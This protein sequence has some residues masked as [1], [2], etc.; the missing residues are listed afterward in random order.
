MNTWISAS[1]GRLAV[2]ALLAAS[3]GLCGS[4]L[5]AHELSAPILALT[6]NGVLEGVRAGGVDEFLGVPYAAPPIGALRFRPPAPHAPW[7]APLRATAFGSPCPQDAALGTP[8]TNE[9]CLSLNIFRPD[10]GGPRRPFLVFFFGGSFKNGSAGVGKSPVGPNYDGA[11]IAQRTGAIVITVNYRLGALGFPRAPRVGCRRS[12]SCLGQLWSVGPAGGAALDPCKCA[13]VGRAIRAASRC[14]VNRPARSRSS[15]IWCRR[16]RVVWFA[17]AELESPGALPTATLQDLETL[18]APIVAATGCATATDIAACLRALPVETLVNSDVPVGPN[19]DGAVIP[20]D[21]DVALAAGSF[22][23][24]PVI[25][26]TDANEGTFFIAA[27]AGN[28]AVDGAAL[29][30]TLAAEFGAAA[31]AQI[32]T[33]YPVSAEGTPGRHWRRY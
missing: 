22:A 19:I 33:Q 14:S 31:A 6:Q 1:R 18:D 23:H 11:W 25:V 30:R 3:L 27:A 10:W 21:P 20:G 17:G 5:A 26:G 32:K 9:D 13:P 8:S 2:G 16:R 29:D 4:S 24:V 12:G 15:S 7:S 28:E